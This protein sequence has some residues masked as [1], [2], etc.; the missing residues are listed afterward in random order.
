MNIHLEHH[1]A[2]LLYKSIRKELSATEAEELEQWRKASPEHE[3]FYRRV[4]EEEYIDRELSLFIRGE[5]RNAL[6]WENIRQRNA[7]N[8][9]KKLRRMVGWS[10]V[11]ALLCLLLGSLYFFRPVDAE[12]PVV[13]SATVI[14]GT[15]KAIL[16][17]GNGR[18]F[19]LSDSV[20]QGIGDGVRS[21]ANQLEYQ[22]GEQAGKVEYHR[23]MIPRGGEYSLILS[24]GTKVF[25]NSESEL[26]Y[27]VVFEGN[28]REV[29]LKGEAFFEVSPDVRK[30]FVVRVEDMQVKVLGTSF[31]VN[32]YDPA[33]I[34]AA[35]VSGKIAVGVDG[36]KG[37]WQMKPSELLRFDRENKTVTIEETDLWPYVAWKEGQFLFRNQ[38]V[39]KIMDIL[40]RWYDIE[41]EYRNESIK[42]LHFTGD[43]RRHADIAVILNALTASVNV[44]YRLENR[45]LTLYCN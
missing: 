42:N 9:R 19:E 10:S 6:L 43:I 45:K 5:N 17:T 24:D 4:Q 23:L 26:S 2:G 25:L 38:S 39:E 32:A 41:V 15:Y 27:P 22:V 7:L 29:S 1:L 34:E 35:L 28:K 30:P 37:E 3:S 11:A 33:Y 14:P 13:V 8:Q 21:N 31:N 18:K 36:K 16:Y 44:K 20:S 12:K 40:S